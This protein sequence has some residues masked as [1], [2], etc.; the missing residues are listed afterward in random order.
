MITINTKLEK[1]DFSKAIKL[2]FWSLKEFKKILSWPAYIFYL[3]STFGQGFYRIGS[4][5]LTAYILNLLA[6]VYT[7]HSIEPFMYQII[8]VSL[9]VALWRLIDALFWGRLGYLIKLAYINNKLLKA[10]DLKRLQNFTYL[11]YSDVQNPNMQSLLRDVLDRGGTS[12]YVRMFHKYIHYVI[13]GFII[14]ATSVVLLLKYMPFLFALVVIFAIT[15]LYSSKVLSKYWLTFFQ[16]SQDYNKFVRRFKNNMLLLDTYLKIKETF[17]EKYFTNVVKKI[18]ELFIFSAEFGVKKAIKH[19]VVPL[20]I[21]VSIMGL[22]IYFSIKAVAEGTMKIGTYSM[23]HSSVF[24]T[25]GNVRTVLEAFE[26]LNTKFIP[27]LWQMYKLENFVNEQKKQ[28]HYV[29]K[30][31]LDKAIAKYTTGK[32]DVLEFKDV[33]FSYDKEFSKF[34]GLETRQDVGKTTRGFTLKNINLTI[35]NG[36]NIAIVGENGAGKS[37]FLKL[38]MGLFKPHQGQIQVLGINPLEIADGNK[39]NIYSVVNQEFMQFSFL[40]IYSFVKLDNLVITNTPFID[41]DRQKFK[42]IVQ[43]IF[44]GKH[45]NILEKVQIPYSDDKRFWYV[46]KLVGLDKKVR[47]FPNGPNTYLSP[48]FKNGTGLSSG[49]WQRLHIARS[50]YTLRPVHILDEP[51]SAIDPV[52][53][54]QIIDNV[55]KELR[56]QTVLLVSHRYSLVK[57]ADLILVFKDGH[58]IEQGNH[59][60]LMK[61][62]GYYYNAYE[63]EARKFAK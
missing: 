52:A 21:D 43:E 14:T 2:L 24:N 1:A 25:L 63:I 55:Y 31:E 62:K 59:K 29:S 19:D 30:V 40:N 34:K 3:I 17:F 56:K 8:F 61:Q 35:E 20:S 41:T 47:E 12:D 9:V 10:W 49:Q 33:Y 18:D 48:S 53:G 6:Q 23:L 22:L 15:G 26:Q 57:D 37:T 27:Y 16:S 39:P 5:F 7:T 4:W 13:N 50:L 60:Q 58:I 46:L 28:M 44:K 54:F 51:T 42:K 45:Q 11:S 32:N 36:A 38:A